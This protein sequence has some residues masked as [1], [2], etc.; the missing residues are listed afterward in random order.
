MPAPSKGNTQ[1]GKAPAPVQRIPFPRAATEH[2]EPFVDLTTAAISA[3]TQP[4]GPFDVPAY[5]YMRDIVLLVTTGTAGSGGGATT[6]ED[7]PFSAFQEVVLQDVNGAPIFG[8]VSGYD[9]YLATKY[10]SYDFSCDPRQSPS[11]SA[12]NATTGALA[13][14]VKI[15]V[16]IVERDAL[17]AIANQN[18][19]STYKLR[20]TINNS[21]GIFAT[22]PVT[23]LPTLRIRA[24]LEAWAQPSTTDLRGLLQETQPPAHGTSQYWS[25]YT[26]VALNGSQTVRLTRM[27]NYI[28]NVIFVCRRNASTR[29]NGETD[30]PDPAATYW[31]TRL[32]HS[33]TKAV[34]RDTIKQR[35]GY[36]AAAEAAGGFDNGVFVY[37]FCHE[38]DGKMGRELREGY[39]PTVQSTRLEMQGTFGNTDNLDI[40]TNDVAAA[41]EIW[42]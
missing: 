11:F 10:G 4:F 40:I 38:F 23:T 20:F 3:S 28:R 31:D 19:S 21:A 18:A 25:K 29:A 6:A 14:S 8:P 42:G 1:A 16:E 22:P 26:A 2:I 30:F 9:L 32:L 41:G 13:F 35:T 36:T 5:G 37:D 27:G 33:Y 12:V 15:P 24:Y 17:G 39:L 34:W 7:G